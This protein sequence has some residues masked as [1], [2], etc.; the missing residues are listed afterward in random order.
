MINPHNPE[1]SQTL[2]ETLGQRVHDLQQTQTTG[3]IISHDQLAD[4]LTLAHERTGNN[5]HLR[6]CLGMVRY[7]LDHPGSTQTTATTPVKTEFLQTIYD[8]CV[9]PAP[10]AMSSKPLTELWPLRRAG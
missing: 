7:L 9:S 2:L 1:E 6:S 8:L 4:A 5:P 10:P 3:T